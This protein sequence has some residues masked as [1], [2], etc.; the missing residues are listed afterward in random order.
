MNAGRATKVTRTVKACQTLPCRSRILLT[1]LRMNKSYVHVRNFFE[2]IWLRR[3]TKSTSSRGQCLAK[4]N[5]FF[6]IPQT[7][8]HMQCINIHVYCA[9]APVSSIRGFYRC[10]GLRHAVSTSCAANTSFSSLD[11]SRLRKPSHVGDTHALVDRHPRP[12][13][14]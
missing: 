2:Y 1:I 3:A 4:G 5:H 12:I 14:H 9:R 7:V 8:H 11:A 13:H 10:H 6:P